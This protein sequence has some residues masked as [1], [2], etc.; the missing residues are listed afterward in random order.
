M[1]KHSDCKNFTSIDVF[2]GYCRRIKDF[3][4]ID[5]PTCPAFME[6]PKCRNCRHF[7]S[8]DEDEIGLCKGM[9]REYWAYG[10]MNAKTCEGYS[11]KQ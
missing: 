1:K 4:L 10:E 5:A 11:V 8:A 3:V 6:A 9:S 2:K 7:C